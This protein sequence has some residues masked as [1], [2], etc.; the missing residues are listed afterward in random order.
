VYT[1]YI[2][3]SLVITLL[4]LLNAF[5]ILKFEQVIPP[6]YS[7]V[8]DSRVKVFWD[9]EQQWYAGFCK[10][11]VDGQPNVWRIRFDD[12]DELPAVHSKDLVDEANFNEHNGSIRKIIGREVVNSNGSMSTSTSMSMSSS[13]MQHKPVAIVESVVSFLICFLLKPFIN[14]HICY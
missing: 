8:V 10:A 5:A 2:F 12:G 6:A 4:H 14:N 13:D 3:F 7:F 1:N 11:K 9:K